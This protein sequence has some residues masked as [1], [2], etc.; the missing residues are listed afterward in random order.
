MLRRTQ[1]YIG[2][3][4]SARDDRSELQLGCQRTIAFC[5]RLEAVAVR[6]QGEWESST[7]V[8]THFE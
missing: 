3:P 2:V 7:V 1:H 5:A 4:D 6:L 8:V